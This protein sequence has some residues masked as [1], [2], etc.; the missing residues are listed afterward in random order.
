MN[1][2]LNKSSSFKVLEQSKKGKLPIINKERELVALC[3]RTD[4]KKIREYP[5]ASKDSNNQLLVGAAIST[6]DKDWARLE[7]LKEAKVH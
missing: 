5:D 2:I 7:M 1:E 6:H 4:L 3:A